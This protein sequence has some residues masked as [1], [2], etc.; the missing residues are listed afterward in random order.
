MVKIK[1]QDELFGEKEI[2]ELEESLKESR[3]ARKVRTDGPLDSFSEDLK[4]SIKK[5][6]K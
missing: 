4:K 3:R 6:D 5:H 1:D 2:K